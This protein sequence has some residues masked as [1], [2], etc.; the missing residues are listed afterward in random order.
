MKTLAKATIHSLTELD[1][2]TKSLVSVVKP[3]SICLFYA[4]M[5]A[6]KT[7]FV[8]SFM[9]HLGIDSITSPTYTL[10]NEYH[11]NPPVYHMDLYRLESEA[12]I[13]SLDLEYYFSQSQYL[14]FIE[15]AEKL[16]DI[17]F[18]YISISITQQDSSRIIDVSLR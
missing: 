11:S 13:D 18:P 1:D 16:I 2:F 7:T 12:A 17:N 4:E 10:I 6:G 9:S 14:F 5:G 3:G 8:K 15:W